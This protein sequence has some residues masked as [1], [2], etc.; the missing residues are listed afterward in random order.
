MLKQDASER[1]VSNKNLGSG[2]VKDDRRMKHLLDTIK[3]YDTAYPSSFP[4]L[5]INIH[6]SIATTA[7][8]PYYY[9]QQGQSQGNAQPSQQQQQQQQHPQGYELYGA[10]QAYY[11]QYQQYQ[12]YYQYQQQQQLPWTTTGASASAAIASALPASYSTPLPPAK[13]KQNQKKV[14]SNPLSQ[15]QAQYQ[16]STQMGAAA[17]SAA[18]AALFQ[19]GY[20][21][22]SVISTPATDSA[23]SSASGTPPSTVEWSDSAQ[24]QQQDWY[25]TYQ[26]PSLQQRMAAT[27]AMNAPTPGRSSFG[28]Q[29]ARRNNNTNRGPQQ[30][31]GKNTNHPKGRQ[32]NQQQKQKQF[33]GE[34]AAAVED[35]SMDSTAGFHCDACDV[36]FHEA[37]KLQTHVAAHR[38]CPDCQYTASPSL[39]SDHRKL[40]HGPKNDTENTLASS[41]ASP[42]VI[43]GSATNIHTPAASAATPTNRPQNSRSQK[44]KPVINPELL[45]P[46]TPSLNTPEEIA[47]WIAQRR[48]A[49]PTEANIQKKEQERQEMIAKGQLVDDPSTKNRNG[50]DKRNKFNNKRGQQFEP[51]S[52]LDGN[53][54][55]KKAKTDGSLTEI[56]TAVEAGEPVPCPSSADPG[57]NDEDEDDTMDPLRDA[58]TSKDPSVMGKV[59]LPIERSTRPKRPCKYFLR[60]H[61]TRGDKCTFSHDPSLKNKV[62]KTNPASNKKEVFRSRPSLL[63]MLLSDEIKQEKNKLLEAMRFIVERGFFE[64]Q[65]PTG[66]LVEEVVM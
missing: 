19:F 27:M 47:A 7:M 26:T 41:S 5:D 64:K 10:D 20:S 31:N 35:A 32:Q 54:A 17:A 65:E 52:E 61:C 6:S 29:N 45:H 28:N 24:Q 46:L 50:R 1:L 39:V 42:S 22:S 58:L 4:L 23:T 12:Q 16:S 37:L 11:Q 51:V 53:L 14:Q 3:H 9:S 8:E 30:R 48:K 57:E 40:S 56:T 25:S 55:N 66:T 44:P 63:Q 33:K 15:Y 2:S 18:A 13:S 62:Q 21:G 36:T 38:S 60:G 43:P 34:T 49:W 59:L